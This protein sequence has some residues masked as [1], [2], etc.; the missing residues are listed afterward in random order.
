M[1]LGY[2]LSSEEHAPNDL[3]AHARQ[4]EEAGF[5]FALIS[6]HFHP[7]VDR[8]GH[9]AFVWSVIGGIA[10]ATRTLRLGTGVTCPL[11][12]IHPAVIAQAAATSAAMLP[13]RFFLGVGTGE[14]LNEHILGDHWPEADVRLQMLE[15][16]IAVMRLLW[17]GETVS[18]RGQFYTVE[19]ARIYTRPQEPIPIMVAASGPKAATLA[20]RIGDGFVG[21]APNGDAIKSFQDA[22]GR[23]KHRYGQMTVCWAADEASARRLAYE[24]WPNAGLGGEL[25]Q[26]LKLPAHFQQASATVSEDDVAKAV[27]CGPDAQRHLE[28]IRAYEQAGYDHIYVHQIG[29]DQQGFFRFYQREILPALQAVTPEGAKLTRSSG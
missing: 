19:N 12:R 24:I 5:R 22:G 8:Q 28:K 6:D 13:G 29:P 23:G 3:V 26:E 18:H 15:E 10:Q 11:I 27:V 17:R 7:W 25:S 2:A 1:E 9:S 20:G 16:A 14:N 21:T 4:A